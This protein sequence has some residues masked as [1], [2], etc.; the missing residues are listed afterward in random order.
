MKYKEIIEKLPYAPPF[1]FVDRLH[2][3]DEHGA[4]GSFTFHE[5][6]DFY[7]GHF[8]EHPVTPG[9][10]LT[11]CCAQIGLVSYGIYLLIKSDTLS[12]SYG[13]AVALTSTE[14]EFLKP[15]YPKERVIVKS[16]KIYFRFQ[17]LRCEVKM[18]NERG[19]LVCQGT[20][21]GMLTDGGNEH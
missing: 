11:E 16:S 8:K 5:E 12:N 15:V 2:H 1:L 19:E 20:L 13:M 17:K 4:E 21:A 18:Y 3:V 10:I 7:K 6:L 14:M 9:V